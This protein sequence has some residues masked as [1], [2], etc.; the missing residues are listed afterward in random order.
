MGLKTKELLAQR[1]QIENHLGRGGNSQVYLANDTKSG[2][3]RAVK[4]INKPGKNRIYAYARREA[5]IVRTLRYPYFPEI[6][7]IVETDQ[8]DFII[9]EYLEGETAGER[10][11]R[12]G[13]L[14]AEDVVRMAKDLCLMLSYLHHYTPPM[15]YCDMK[16]DNIM[17]QAEGNLRLID[18]GAVMQSGKGSKESCLRLGTRGYAAPEQ[19]DMGRDIDAR[20]D[21]YA[22][23]VTMYQLLTGKGPGQT[24]GNTE[25][26][27]LFG[28][29]F[30]RSLPRKLEKII[31]KCMREDPAERYQDCEELREDLSRVFHGKRGNK[32]DI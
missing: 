21:I 2:R 5:E 24:E 4:E 20:T 10:L 25:S 28:R 27:K 17:V 31:H 13:S 3:K 30:R 29:G 18:F 8:A 26:S 6:F 16:P 9:M 19:F 15:V 11:R 23:G 14:S 7:D 1:Y 12:L 22:L 32:L